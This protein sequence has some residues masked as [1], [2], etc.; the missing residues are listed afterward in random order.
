MA[1]TEIRRKWSGNGP[2]L[3]SMRA[4]KYFIRRVA[5]EGISSAEKT[6]NRQEILSLF[7]QN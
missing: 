4:I 6:D 3:M 7:Y 1:A 5:D 2:K